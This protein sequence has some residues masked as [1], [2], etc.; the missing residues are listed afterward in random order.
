MER[1]GARFNKDMQDVGFRPHGY[2]GPSLLSSSCD[3]DCFAWKIGFAVGIGVLVAL[4]TISAYECHQ[5]RRD[6]EPVLQALKA[7]SRL[8][9]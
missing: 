2:C 1:R 6:A 4:L 7:G 8:V 5:V 9:S 3:N